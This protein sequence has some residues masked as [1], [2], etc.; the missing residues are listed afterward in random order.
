M[1]TFYTQALIVILVSPKGASRILN[2]PGQAR[3]TAN[4]R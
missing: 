3:I 1:I 4:F 2:D